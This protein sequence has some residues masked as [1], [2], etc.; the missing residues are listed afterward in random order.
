MTWTYE[1]SKATSKSNN[2]PFDG[3]EIKGRTILTLCDGKVAYQF[4]TAT[5]RWIAIEGLALK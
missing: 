1:V 3:R 4:E 2:S 5:N